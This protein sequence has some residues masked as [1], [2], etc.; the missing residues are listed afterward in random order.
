MI[1]GLGK[2]L[3]FM[4]FTRVDIIDRH[5]ATSNVHFACCAWKFWKHESRT[6]KNTVVTEMLTNPIFAPQKL[7]LN[8]L[9]SIAASES[10]GYFMPLL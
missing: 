4:E 9:G 10:G 8:F 3:I 2:R 5:S 6:P 7:W 1:D